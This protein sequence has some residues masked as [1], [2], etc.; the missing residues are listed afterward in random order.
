MSPLL[1]GLLAWTPA[2][3]AMVAIWTVSSGPVPERIAPT[4]DF[5][6]KLFHAV[7][8]AVLALLTSV[9]ANGSVPPRRRGTR[10]TWLVAIL[11]AAGYGVVDEVHQSFVPSRSS[12]A[13]DALADAVGSVLGASLA[14]L[15][16]W[17]RRAAPPGSGAPRHP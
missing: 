16:Y 7:G 5:G 11:V 2:G 12:D 4:F 10:R 9:G 13:L 6:D 3:L 17:R 15:G 8:Y 1:R 14:H